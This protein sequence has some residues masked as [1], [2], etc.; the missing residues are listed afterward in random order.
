MNNPD[1]LFDI[2]VCIGPHDNDIVSDVLPYTKRNVIGYRNIYLVCSNPNISIPGTI[3]IDEKI[4]PFTISDLQIMF[5]NNDRNGWYL[6]QL[7]KF[8]AGN[9]IPGILKRYL[10]IDCDTYFLKPTKFI[11]DDGKHLYTTGKHN[12]S[13]YFLHMNRLHPSLK[14]TNPLSGIAHHCFFHT[15]MVNELMQ[16]IE[17]SF[18]NQSVFWKIFLQNIDMKEFAASGAS[19]YEIYFTFMN[20]YHSN[21]MVI[22][23][24]KWEN[25]SRLDINNKN[26][27]DYV[28]VHWYLRK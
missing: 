25:V 19:E 13:P 6:Q 3:T 8:Y 21:D 5:G 4:F 26:D 2:V 17:E 1:L 15:D 20:L 23:Q 14:K 28:S 22:R 7:L 9:V 16:L 12:H 27:C 18:S 10:V 24:L 11:N